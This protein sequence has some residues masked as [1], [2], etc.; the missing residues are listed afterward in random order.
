MGGMRSEQNRNRY[1]T[2]AFRMSD[3]ELT[4]LEKRIKLSGRNKQDY[5]IKSTLYQTIVVLGNRIQFESL[6][7]QLDEIVEH[8]RSLE[9]ASDL[10]LDKLAPVR[11]A[12]EIITGFTNADK[13]WDDNG[14]T[15]T[16]KNAQKSEEYENREI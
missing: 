7:D 15:F 12:I 14:M 13:N 10:D 3:E 4:E 2:V 11:T 9:K 16:P 6:R 1:R 8:L 5:F